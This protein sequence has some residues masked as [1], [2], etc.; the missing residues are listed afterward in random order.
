MT[1]EWSSEAHRPADK[2]SQPSI[3][4]G[5]EGKEKTSAK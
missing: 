1:I 4:E 3:D 5:R 2:P